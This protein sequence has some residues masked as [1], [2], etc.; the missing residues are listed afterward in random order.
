M[1]RIEV[2]DTGPGVPDD[3][4]IRIFDRFQQV[5]KSKGHRRGTGLGLTFCRLTV[6]AH[7]GRIWIEDNPTGGSIFV[8]TLPLAIRREEKEAQ[9]DRSR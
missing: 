6:E 3:Y 7:G 4:K 1:A 9:D 2:T 8:F 5:D